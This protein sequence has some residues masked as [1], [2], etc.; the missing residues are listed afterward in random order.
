MGK[1][2]RALRRNTALFEPLE[3]RQLFAAALGAN[4]IVNPGAEAG[5]AASNSTDAFALPGWTKNDGNITAV[6]YGASGG[7]PTSSTP[8]PSNRGKNF[9]AGGPNGN[10]AMI[11][12]I[13]VSSQATAIDAKKIHFTLSGWLGGFGTDQDHV[14]VQT[15]FLD[16]SGHAINA[17]SPAII[18]PVTAAD[19]GNDT[20]LISKSVTDVLPT[21]TRNVRI[22][23]FFERLDGVYNDAYADNFS[24]VLTNPSAA[25]NGTVSGSVF[26]DTNGNGIQSGSTETGLSGW[27]VY[28]DSNND[29]QYD[30]GE[31][32]TTTNSSGAF[33]LTLKPGKYTIR[34]QVRSGFA[35]TTPKTFGFSINLMS[36]GKITGE[37]F[38][39]KPV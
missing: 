29:S 30:P 15:L 36:G 34:V 6:K 19:R 25:A 38:G 32:F 16:S 21:G 24:F 14:T 39:M 17:K 9:F 5:S 2:L 10:S 37:K 3:G 23:V 31:T 1:T 11:Q 35:A 7:F 22:G 33:T 27:M 20:K 28:V 4:L 12:L 13:N 8:G 26:K 18:G